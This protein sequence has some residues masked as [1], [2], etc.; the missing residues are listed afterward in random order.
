MSK[1]KKGAGV[2]APAANRARAAKAE[3]AARPVTGKAGGSPR[4][5][6]REKAV[7]RKDPRKVARKPVRTPS[8]GTAVK[9]TPRKVAKK[10]AKPARAKPAASR[11]KAKRTVGKATPKGKRTTA[12]KAAVPRT[13]KIRELDPVLKCG[14]DTSVQFLYRVD[15]QREGAPLTAHLVFFDRHGWYCEHGRN[16]PAVADVRKHGRMHHLFGD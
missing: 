6:S 7:E 16:C 3:E 12:T 10:K 8:K 9:A 13:V 2:T 11:G 5:A 4:P 15:E 1:V 14:P